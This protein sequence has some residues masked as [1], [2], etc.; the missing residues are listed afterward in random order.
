MTSPVV[1]HINP[2]AERTLRFGHPWLYAE[3]I[4]KQSHAAPPGTLAAVYDKRE[5]LLAIGLYDPSSPIRVRVLQR[6]KSAPINAAWF[7]E[8]FMKALALREPLLQSKTTTGYRLVHGENDGLPGLVLDRYGEMLVMKLY[9][10]AWA[11]HLPDL[12]EALTGVVPVQ[13]IVLRLSRGAQRTGAALGLTDGIALAGRVPERAVTF[14]EAGLTF[15]VD[16]LQGQK[17]GF[18]LDQRD[19]RAELARHTRGKRVLD[20]FAYT[21]GFSVAAARGGATE[22]TSLDASEP[23]LKAAQRNFALNKKERLVAK[24]KHQVMAGDAFKLL[25][26]LGARRQR[27]EVVVIDPPSFAKTRREVEK[28]LAAYRQLT[29]LGL[30]VLAPGG[31]LMISCCS[32][33]VEANDFYAAVH[34]A[35]G[36]S[37]RVLRELART[38]Q[39]ID[40]P[41]SFREGAYLKSVFASAATRAAR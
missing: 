34:H 11:P 5:R 21:G 22:I 9:T 10:A 15:E 29:T 41:I 33:Q 12:V 1:L 16:V 26:Q 14:R 40:H 30:A 36:R 4:S 7:R 39:P 23:A 35:A 37:R 31:T 6:G 28:A 24:A 20:V 18:F 13:D 38:G 3:A 27:Y 25:E 17:T 32:G 2:D 19:N 8:R